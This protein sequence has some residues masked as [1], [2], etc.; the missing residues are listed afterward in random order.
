MTINETIFINGR[1]FT[2][3]STG[4]QRF[5]FELLNAL[6]MLLESDQTFINSTK[7][8]CLV[9]NK[10]KG[11]LLPHWKN[12]QIVVSGHLQDNLWEQIEL[13]F[14]SRQG[15]LLN[16]CNIGP[17]F[18]FNQITVLH[19][20]S[21]F[22]VPE[23]YSFLFKMKYRLIMWILGRTSKQILTVS[24][25]SK[26]ELARYL[27]IREN[28]ISIIPE[29][30]EHILSVSPDENILVDGRLPLTPYLLMVG[31]SSLH[32]N[33]NTVIEAIELINDFPIP[34][35]IAGGSFS[36]VFKTY[37]QYESQNIISLG[38]VTESELRTLFSKAIGFIF[39]SKYEGFGLPPLEA[40]ACGCPVI[41]SINASI[42]EICGDAA[43]YFN[44][45]NIDEIASQIEYLVSDSS[46]RESLKKKG[47]IRSKLFT[48][49]DSAKM[50][51]KLLSI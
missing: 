39:P 37:N 19:D 4:V 25:F 35:V 36:N 7:I 41:C 22:A 21:V 18:H 9:P 3:P 13:P 30:C 49:N 50:L 31:S 11:Y 44:P 38:Y 40:M 47:Y 46:L 29:G 2:Q 43:L 26:K 8:I 34:L 1:F 51:L 6:D 23:T 28:K 17:I 20:A 42:P 32:K 16:L 5:A 15:L 45:Y 27:K 24:N 14:L 10:T 33:I 48:W 12:I